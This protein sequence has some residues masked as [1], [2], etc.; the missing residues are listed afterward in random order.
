M[1]S[2]LLLGIPTQYNEIQHISFNQE[3]LARGDERN[4]TFSSTDEILLCAEWWYSICI[5]V[6][7]FI[8]LARL[9]G[10]ASKPAPP[11]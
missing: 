7:M 2:N 4:N 5:Q 3:Q 9:P 10:H 11:S 8:T 1:T 6:V